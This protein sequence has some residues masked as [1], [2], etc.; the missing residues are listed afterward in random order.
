MERLDNIIAGAIG[1]TLVGAFLLGLAESIG[2]IP[3]W[4]ITVG[5]L[6][7]CLVDYYEDGL[8]KKNGRKEP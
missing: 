8:K 6:C 3:F 4:F 7:L 2:A 5:V 1:V